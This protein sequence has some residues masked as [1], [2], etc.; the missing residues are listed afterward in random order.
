MFQL[1]PEV[2]TE[3]THT[4]CTS[5]PRATLSIEVRIDY[6]DKFNAFLDLCTF[7]G[8]SSMSL[9]HML[10]LTLL[11]DTLA[12][13]KNCTAAAIPSLHDPVHRSFEWA[14]LGSFEAMRYKHITFSISMIFR[15]VLDHSQGETIIH[16]SI[17]WRWIL[18]SVR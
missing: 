1:A 11:Y 18:V 7:I 2:A 5:V 16:G 9:F 10:Q 8:L 4:T 6:L 12:H 14:P 15:K 13:Q 3:A 17:N